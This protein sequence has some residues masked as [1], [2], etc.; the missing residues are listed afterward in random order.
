MLHCGGKGA[1]NVSAETNLLL[2]L[3]FR[4]GGAGAGRVACFVIRTCDVGDEAC[5]RS[6]NRAWMQLFQ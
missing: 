5:R 1:Q 6:A 4:G 2:D 3:L